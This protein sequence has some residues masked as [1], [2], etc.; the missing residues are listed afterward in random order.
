VISCDTD[1]PTSFDVL[2]FQDVGINGFNALCDPLILI[3]NRSL[4]R[5]FEWLSNPLTVNINGLNDALN[6]LTVKIDS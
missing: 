4:N 6:P 5:Y 2:L 3:V 1:V